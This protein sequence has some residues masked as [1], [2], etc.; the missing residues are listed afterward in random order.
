MPAR[1]PWE[2]RAGGDPWGEGQGQGLA[3]WW[4]PARDGPQDLAG[5]PKLPWLCSLLWQAS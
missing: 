1:Q 4:A 3:G 5:P 2:G